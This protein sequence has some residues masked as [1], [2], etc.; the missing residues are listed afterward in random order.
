MRVLYVSDRYCVHDHRFLSAIREAGFETHFLP[1]STSAGGD[2]RPLPEGVVEHKAVGLPAQAGVLALYR[3]LPIFQRR[4]GEVRPDL[5]HAGPVHRGA[6]MAALS[7]FHPLVTMSWGWDLLKAGKAPIQR[8]L[9]RFTLR[10][11]DAFI[12]DCQAVRSAAMDLGM[13]E[14]RMA[15][16][17]W[18]VDLE[19]FRPGRE[20]ELL[21]RMGWDDAFVVITTRAFEP[22]YDPETVAEGFILAS[23][24]APD[25]RWLALGE[26]SLKPRVT[27][28]VEAAGLRG[29][30]HFAGS[31]GYETL[32][33]Y[34]RAAD[35]YVSASLVD[36]SSVSLMEALASGLPAAVSDIPGNREWVSQGEN[37]WL[38]PVR[39]AASL[40]TLILD[41]RGDAETRRRMGVT[42]RRI[43][44]ARA[45]WSVHKAKLREAYAVAIKH[46]GRRVT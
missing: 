4:L 1:L 10:R 11:S 31:V 27:E 22:M 9:A 8:W 46:V 24:Q 15:I 26:G 5:V 45:D 42:A 23:A 38:F 43:A 37:G 30:V 18:G 19:R 17:P 7:G 36:G 28:R 20:P 21:A 3:H 25:L 13:P 41:A 39:D 14:G 12:G 32:P 33:S 40:G 29:R 44:E 16:F 34:F 6:L 35:L 2:S